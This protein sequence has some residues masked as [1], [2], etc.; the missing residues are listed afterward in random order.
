MS[1]WTHIIGSFC[2]REY[3]P[4]RGYAEDMR[5]LF[6]TKKFPHITGSEQDIEIFVN[7]SKHLGY[8][9]HVDCKKCQFADFKNDDC[10]ATADDD[11]TLTRFPEKY[12]ITIFGNLRDRSLKQTKEECLAFI[13]E[14]EATFDLLENYSI[15]IS[16]GTKTIKLGEYK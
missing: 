2:I 12:F 3:H 16:N 4:Y 14:L 10:L 11:C 7:S 6:K 8:N 1:T 9:G 5:N 15:T 13:A